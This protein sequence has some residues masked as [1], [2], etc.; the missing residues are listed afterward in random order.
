MTGSD[1]KREIGVW[2]LSSNL[3]NTMIGAGIFVLPAMVAAGLGPASILAYLFC[4]FLI[5]L[6]MLCFAEVGSIITSDGGVYAYI[7]QA[8]GDYFGFNAATLFLLAAISADAAVAHAL[9]DI[10]DSILPIEF[11]K[12]LTFLCFFLIFGGLAFINII[13]VKKGVTLVKAIT[14]AKLAPL[15]L[16]VLFVSR[17]VQL[18]YLAWSETP[19]L[20]ELGQISLLLFF[21]FQGAESGLSVSGE[22]RD[23]R[24]TIPRSIFISIGVVLMIYLLI[25]TI[26]QGVLGPSLTLFQE[27]PLGEVASKVIGPLGL[28]LMTIGAGVSMFGNLSS[29]VLS[30][31]RIL[32]GAS[33]DR[34]IP[35]KAL[36]RIHPKYATPAVA[37][38]VY[39][40][41]DFIFALFGGFRQ[42]AI[43]SSATVL[44][45]YFGMAMAVIRLRLKKEAAPR[46]SFKIPGGYV[47]PVATGLVILWF[48]SSL[49]GREILGMLLIVALLTIVYLLLK[50]FKPKERSPN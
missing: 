36:A 15:L 24:R 17:D 23:P 27:N 9:I 21:A 45:V 8:L 18:Q 32:F 35:V 37:I 6:V 31:P 22:V 20:G 41:L 3:I 10:A 7:D 14:F 40:G 48:L 26:S 4:G 2:G 43:L 19:T 13:G 42:L 34:V 47:V 33:K 25:Q 29:E 44:L 28:T 49:T 39:A 50:K 11:G 30:M 5:S 16:F 12:P 1:L 38:L 46:D